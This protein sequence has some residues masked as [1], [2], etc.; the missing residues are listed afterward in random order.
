MQ[1]AYYDDFNEIKKKI[2][3]KGTIL[4]NTYTFQVLRYKK[5]FVYEKPIKKEEE[6]DPWADRFSSSKDK[7]IL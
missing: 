2:G 4:I 3:V 1:P 5:K 6:V 7:Y